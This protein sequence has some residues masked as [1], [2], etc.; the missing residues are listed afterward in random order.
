[1]TR[2][3]ALALTFAFASASFASLMTTQITP[4]PG[5]NGLLS[6][7]TNSVS[8]AGISGLAYL[9]NPS[10]TFTFANRSL[11]PLTTPWAHRRSRQTLACSPLISALDSLVGWLT[12]DTMV[13]ISPKYSFFAGSCVVTS[14]TSGF[15]S[16]A[17]P[18]VQPLT[19][20]S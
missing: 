1:M 2:K 4:G 11:S 16:A 5:T 3:L 10:E 7:G 13:T 18:L 17:L 14:S 15:V 20:T 12:L 19:W 6:I 9:G 8:F